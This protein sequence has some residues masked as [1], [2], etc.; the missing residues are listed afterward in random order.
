MGTTFSVSDKRC[1]TPDLRTAEGIKSKQE[2][3]ISLL[4]KPLDTVGTMIL[5]MED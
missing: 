4:V 2:G 1:Q 5:A 3:Q